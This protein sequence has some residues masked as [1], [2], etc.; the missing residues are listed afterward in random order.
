MKIRHQTWRRFAWTGG[1]LAIPAAFFLF[2]QPDIGVW[3]HRLEIAAFAFIFSLGGLGGLLAIL[4]RM[5]GVQFTYS[6]ADKRTLAYRLSKLVAEM[7]HAQGRG[8]SARYYES[9]GVTQPKQAKSDDKP[10]A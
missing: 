8:F 7:E 1:I 9:L 4:S 2:I 5:G 6:D 10:A 3:T